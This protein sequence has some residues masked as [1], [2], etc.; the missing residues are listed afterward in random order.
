M[1]GLPKEYAVAVAG[2]SFG[3]DMWHRAGEWPGPQPRNHLIL[4]NSFLPR[5]SE[6]AFQR[7]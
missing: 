3:K 5:L 2:G 7:C 4:F 1:S 6:F